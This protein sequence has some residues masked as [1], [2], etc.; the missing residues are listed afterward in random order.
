MRNDET[1]S[2]SLRALQNLVTGNEGNVDA[3]SASEYKRLF[4]SD[5]TLKE[6]I[7]DALMELQVENYPLACAIAI[8]LER[9]YPW[10]KGA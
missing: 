7:I 9:D 8:E 10:C 2:R 6:M 4:V 5:A 3:V 1:R